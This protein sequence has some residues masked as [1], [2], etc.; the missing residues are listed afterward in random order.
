MGCGLCEAVNEEY[1]IIARDEY[2]VAL[3]IREPQIECHSLV[4]S[5]RHITNWSDLSPEESYSLH[6]LVST[7][8][9]KMDKVLGCSSIAA[10][11]GVSY[12]TQ[13]H[14]HYQVFPVY[15]GLRTIISGHLEIPEKKTVT[16]VELER[17]TK[18]LR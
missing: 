10:I 9:A 5:I 7:L 11:N 14:I 15:D 16:N 3:I 18:K 2:S 6:N 8:T 13:S 4:M 1:R 17:M 12:R